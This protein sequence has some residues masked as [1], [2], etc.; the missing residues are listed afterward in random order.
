MEL[1]FSYT[2]PEGRKTVTY[3]AFCYP[4][5]Y[6]D[7]QKHLIKIEQRISRILNTSPSS[8]SPPPPPSEDSIYYHRDLLCHT[9]D[10]LRVDLLTVSSHRG[11]ATETEP[12]LPGL[13]PDWSTPTARQFKNKKV[14][15]SVIKI[16]LYM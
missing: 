3:F 1:S 11:I 4:F 16:A 9:L 10:G 2:P 13:F 8:S 14:R 15:M 12:R 6:T 7:L 5:S